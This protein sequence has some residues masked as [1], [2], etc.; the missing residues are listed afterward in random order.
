MRNATALLVPTIER[1]ALAGNATKDIEN[2]NVHCDG[3]FWRLH[4]FM[5]GGLSHVVMVLATE[6]D[7]RELTRVL[8]FIHSM[9]N[10]YPFPLNHDIVSVLH[11]P[12]FPLIFLRFLF[13]IPTRK[14]F[15]NPNETID[16]EHGW[17]S[18]SFTRFESC[19]VSL[20]GL[21]QP[22]MCLGGI[23]RCAVW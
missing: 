12:P 14:H 22:R 7:L 17:S 3:E 4:H 19:Y 11:R 9:H 21:V 18:T 16:S 20:V 10:F 1:N 2:Y 8:I 23:Y 6:T 13:H 5:T 15:T